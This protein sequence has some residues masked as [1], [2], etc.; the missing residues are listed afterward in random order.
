M[1]ILPNTSQYFHFILPT[2]L[3]KEIEVEEK[4]QDGMLTKMSKITDLISRLDSFTSTSDGSDQS[5]VKKCYT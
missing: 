3:I 1:D 2:P 5:R 4:F